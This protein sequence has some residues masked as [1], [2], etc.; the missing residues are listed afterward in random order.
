MKTSCRDIAEA[1][2]DYDNPDITV[3]EKK[4]IDEHL[5]VC[6]VCRNALS[7][8]RMLLAKMREEALGAPA[9]F[10]LFQIPEE[11][12]STKVLPVQKA[13]FWQKLA[14][15]QKMWLVPAAGLALIFLAVVLLYFRSDNRS[16]V[17]LLSGAIKSATNLTE[18]NATRPLHQ[19]EKFCCLSPAKISFAA[20][21]AKLQA[22]S[23]FT[24]LAAAVELESGAA[25]F[26]IIP[27]GKGFSVHTS[28]A[29]LGV[30]GTSFRVVVA[31][32]SVRV[33]LFKGRLKVD[34]KGGSKELV[35]SASCK[36]DR[37]GIISPVDQVEPDG[38]EFNH[39]VASESEKIGEVKKIPL[40]VKASDAIVLPPPLVGSSGSESPEEPDDTENENV[41]IQ[42]PDDALLSD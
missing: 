20:G 22:G 31:S 12:R 34:A 17:M 35:G 8:Q 10:P 30:I 1:L 33:N 28:Y 26:D 24:V 41:P 6:P 7:Q 14:E 19:D 3:A 13:G 32:D 29:V 36:I 38:K 18:F 2:S 21:T 9:T 27:S 5:A 42:S 16:Q 15:L 39:R 37:N 25:D 40:E 4:L 23:C 11:K